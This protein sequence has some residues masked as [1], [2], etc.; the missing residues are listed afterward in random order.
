MK[1]VPGWFWNVLK[2]LLTVLALGYVG[3]RLWH[4]RDSLQS[5]LS[6]MNAGSAIW[7]VLAIVFLPLNIGLEATKWRKLVSPFYPEVTLFR[8]LKAVLTGMATGIFTPNRLG[9]YA[10]RV[11]ILPPGKRLE[12][13]LVTFVDRLCQMIAT[14]SFGL[15]ALVAMSADDRGLLAGKLL[16]DPALVSMFY[17]VGVAL[18]LIVWLIV[19]FPGILIRPIIWI[20]PK[21]KFAEHLQF[22]LEHLPSSTVRTV[23]VLSALRYLVFSA[24]YFFLLKAFQFEGGVLQAFPLIALIFLAKSVVPFLAFME[25]G[26]R[27]II[28]IAVFSLAGIGT[29]QA[30]S[31]TFVL[32]LINILTPSVAGAFFVREIRLKE[33]REE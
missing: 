27:E 22:A 4:D 17:W 14:L 26:V 13:V 6:G 1:Q 16:G 8:A 18:L 29:G 10:G 5:A 7:V 21:K 28:A 30:V 32:Y 20:F 24:Q 19:W 31:A 3:F 15:L 2:I 9:E 11:L 33:G 23:I 25:L 12:A